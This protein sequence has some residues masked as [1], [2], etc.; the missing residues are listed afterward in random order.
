MTDCPPSK[1]D[2]YRLHCEARALVYKNG[3]CD[4]CEL[5]DALWSHAVRAGVVEE[6]GADQVQSVLGASFEVVRHG[7]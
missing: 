7:V 2:V 4:L 6:Y 3:A 1:L 5:V